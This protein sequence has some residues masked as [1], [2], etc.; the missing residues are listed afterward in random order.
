MNL[1]GKK[2]KISFLFS[3]FLLLGILLVGHGASAAVEFN[4]YYDLGASDPGT[5]TGSGPTYHRYQDITIPKGCVDSVLIELSTNVGSEW[6]TGTFAGEPMTIQATSTV[7]NNR[8]ITILTIAN[9]LEGTHTL[10]NGL[11]YLTTPTSPG[12]YN[13]Q[14]FLYCG[15]DPDN[16]LAD[17]KIISSSLSSGTVESPTDT[18]LTFF[19]SWMNTAGYSQT[20]NVP[21]GFTD[22]GYSGEWAAQF[23]SAE[24]VADYPVSNFAWTGPNT[25][26]ALIYFTIQKVPSSYVIQYIGIGTEQS[27][28]EGNFNIPFFWDVCDDYNNVDSVSLSAYFDNTT[29]GEPLNLITTD[30]IGP[31]LCRGSG[32]YTTNVNYSSD[33]ESSGI[34]TLDLEVNTKTPSTEYVSTT[35]INYAL[36]TPSETF[37]VGST[38]GFDSS[39]TQSVDTKIGTSTPVMVYWDFRKISDW[40]SSTI[41]IYNAI[42]KTDTNYCFTPTTNSGVGGV[43]LPHSPSN[44]F[45]L[46]FKW[47]AEFPTT[48]DIWDNTLWHIIW[49]TPN[50]IINLPSLNSTSTFFNQTPHDIA[51]TPEEWAATSSFLGLN[52]TIIRCETISSLLTI[53]QSFVNMVK[54]A[55]NGILNSTKLL[56]PVNLFVGINKSWANSASS[57]LPTTLAWLNE[58]VDSDGNITIGGNGPITGTTIATTTIWGKNMSAGNTFWE[59]WRLRIRSLSTW[60]WIGLFLIFQIFFRGKRLLNLLPHAHK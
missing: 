6:S 58:E 8:V 3:L 23:R 29:A 18:G 36:Y 55:I 54:S 16:P 19:T 14:L 45:D 24:L 49:Q 40:A 25:T 17:I 60:F 2:L 9:P 38:L 57:T 10:D 12:I 53:S 59:T 11:G 44:E 51:C 41:C 32:I 30:L 26:G 7:P 34:F 4:T 46:Y 13:R 47:R 35:A 42:S 39:F 31:Q 20:I 48:N 27:D 43:Y 50:E 56:F 1:C 5:T 37:L 15:V 33:L 21:S 22:R 28:Q 52:G